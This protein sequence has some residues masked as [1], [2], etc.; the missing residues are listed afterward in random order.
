[1]ANI[2]KKDK[3]LSLRRKGKSISEIAEKLDAP[4]S[5]VGVWCRNIKLGKKQIERLA[6]RQE[7]GSYRGRMKFLE[8]I[9]KDRLFQ[10]EKLKKEGLSEIK[11]I[12]KRDLFI[13][14]IAMY[15]SEGATSESSEEVSFTNSDYRAVLFIKRWFKEIC[16]VSDDRFII[17]IR[18]NK[19]HKNKVIDAENYWS[20][21][22]NIPVGQF[23][24]TILIKSRSKKVYPKDNIYYGTIR[25]KVRQG[26]QLRRKI[27]GWV[28]G[29]LKIKQD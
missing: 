14:G 27:N 8:R 1:M 6:K 26:T 13:A 15:L 18:I 4:K 10:T 19:I 28:E 25:L 12:S 11:N 22:T 23:S 7:S 21:V 9:R 29:L 20:K 5:T 16:R 17:Q 2:L 24:K 3:A